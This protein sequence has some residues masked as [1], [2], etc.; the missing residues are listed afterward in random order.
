MVVSPVGIFIWL[1][2]S[3]VYMEVY[4]K[5]G[6]KTL[7]T[8]ANEM[9]HDHNKF[10]VRTTRMN[11]VVRIN[12]RSVWKEEEP[13]FYLYKIKVEKKAS[14]LQTTSKCIFKLEILDLSP[15]QSG[16]PWDKVSWESRL[17]TNGTCAVLKLSSYCFYFAKSC[18]GNT[19]TERKEEDMDSKF[20][21]ST[22]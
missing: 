5:S 8:S 12:M 6:M 2:F 9:S 17:C 11:G 3:C 18:H 15:P 4:R 20:I 21:L 19:A 16:L 1:F 7:Y 10:I 14:W 13:E 22:K